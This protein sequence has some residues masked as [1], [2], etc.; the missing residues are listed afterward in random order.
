MKLIRRSTYK[1]FDGDIGSMFEGPYKSLSNCITLVHV[2]LIKVEELHLLESKT[3]EP[4]VI[5]INIA[6]CD[7]T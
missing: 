4:F 5:N 2:I 7:G 1:L 6:M 3:L